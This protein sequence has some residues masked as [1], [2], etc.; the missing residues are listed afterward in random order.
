MV[1]TVRSAVPF[2]KSVV[3]GIQEK[4]VTFMA[5]SIAYQAFVSLIPLLVLLFFLVSFVGD[6]ALADQVSAMTEGF[7]P[8]SGQVML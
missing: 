6:Q 2:A 4:N 8:E 5:A 7:L 3:N 1:S